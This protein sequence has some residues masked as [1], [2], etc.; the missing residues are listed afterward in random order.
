MDIEGREVIKLSV[1]LVLLLDC[2]ISLL[3]HGNSRPP[4]GGLRRI[5]I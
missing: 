5:T 1:A 2:M 3:Y 4:F